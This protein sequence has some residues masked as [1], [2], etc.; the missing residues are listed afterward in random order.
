MISLR[1]GVK[2]GLMKKETLILSDGTK[3][4]GEVKNGKMHGKGTYKLVNGDKY[5]G[6]FKVGK[7]HG[8]GTYT[9]AYKDKYVGEWKNGKMHGKG[10]YTDAY[11]KKYVGEFK[12]GKYYGGGTLTRAKSNYKLSNIKLNCE[13]GEYLLISSLTDLK[14]KENLEKIKYFSSID[15]PDL[16][17]PAA[18]FSSALTDDYGIPYYDCHLFNAVTSDK[19]YKKHLVKF[20]GEEKIL[21]EIKNDEKNGYIERYTPQGIFNYSYN[22]IYFFDNNEDGLFPNI[23]KVLKK[24]NSKQLGF[25][26]NPGNIATSDFIDE[27]ISY[28]RKYKPYDGRLFKIKNNDLVFCCIPDNG[29]SFCKTQFTKSDIEKFSTDMNLFIKDRIK[30]KKLIK[31]K[32]PNG[33]YGIYKFQNNSSGIF[34]NLP[35]IVP[36]FELLGH[37]IKRFNPKIGT[38]GWEERKKRLKKKKLKHK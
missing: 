3:Y 31:F 2:L 21:Q 24:S 9:Y 10:T 14:R 38:I 11:G 20:F 36:N 4:V 8:H 12:D 35:G 29:N 16:E 23:H 27:A 32:V 26:V 25:F 17:P 5:V 6:E 30:R 28:N 13:T 34:K 22:Y 15:Y 1:S 19:F 18:S 37:Y 33:A 7:E